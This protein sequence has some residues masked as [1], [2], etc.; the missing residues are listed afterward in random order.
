MNS[1]EY[2]QFVEAELNKL[3]D[4][5]RAKNSDYTGGSEDAFA[6]FKVTEKLGLSDAETGLLI[7]MVDKIQRVRSFL[8]KGKLEVSNESVEDA[9]KDIIG[10]SLLLLGLLR[11][12]DANK[13]E[14]ACN[15]TRVVTIN[16]DRKSGAV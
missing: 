11:E 15:N 1:K 10:Y 14:R 12:R 7:R 5:L 3:I 4:I 16:S 8:I 13:I 2:I 6:N 9:V